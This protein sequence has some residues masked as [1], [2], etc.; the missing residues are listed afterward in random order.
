MKRL[1]L[2]FCLMFNGCATLKTLPPTYQGVTKLKT[3]SSFDYDNQYQWDS[4]IKTI[5]EKQNKTVLLSLTG[6]GG[7]VS[8]GL[9]FIADIEKLKSEGY[10]I[11]IDVPNYAAS[12]FATLA[13]Y[14]SK[15]IGQG[16][17]MYHSIGI[18]KS[19]QGYRTRSGSDETYNMLKQCTTK[20]ILSSTELN[21]IING[22]EVYIDLST[23][24]HYKK[25]DN[26]PVV[27]EQDK[28]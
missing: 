22:S 5:Y 8:N 2:S 6:N 11:I 24:Y 14:G 27:N 1:I 9:H 20:G 21:D 26:R 17:L 23:N 25:S 15:L 7:L 4:L 13:C 16:Q 10:T 18:I 28:K 12:M 19:N 3:P